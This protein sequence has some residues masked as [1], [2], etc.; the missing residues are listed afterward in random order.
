MHRLGSE[1]QLRDELE[2]EV[3]R[4]SEEA[5]RLQYNLRERTLVSKLERQQVCMFI[6][7]YFYLKFVCA[8][9]SQAVSH[10]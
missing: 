2:Q 9:K 6:F 4:V 3:K 7:S 5:T 10:G 8:L 1:L